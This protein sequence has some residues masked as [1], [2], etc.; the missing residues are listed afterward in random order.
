M[1]ARRSERCRDFDPAHVAYAGSVSKMLAPALR[2][3]WLVLPP[4]LAAAVVAARQLADLGSPAL[5]QLAFA[6]FVESGMLDRHLRRARSTYRESARRACRGVCAPCTGG[7]STRDCGR[8]ACR[9]G[10]AAKQTRERWS[11][12]PRTPGS[13]VRPTA[14]ISP[15]EIPRRFRGWSSAMGGCPAARSQRDRHHSAGVRKRATW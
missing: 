13:R 14:T 15:T 11:R 12:R 8:P 9:G 5:D 1:T 6:R 4:R 2:I 3:G 7:A 10:V